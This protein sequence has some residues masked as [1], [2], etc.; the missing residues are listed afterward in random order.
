MKLIIGLGNPGKK[1]EN[2]RHNV[3]FM[4]VDNVVKNFNGS[5]TLNTKLRCEQF[6][7][8]IKGEKVLF[9]KPITYMNL[10]GESIRLVVDYYKANIE[11]I[12]VIYDDLDLP[13]GKI[14]LRENGSSGGHKGM[15]S[16]IDHLKTNNIKRMRIG[17][18]YIFKKD[19]ID[20]VLGK[21]SKD[22]MDL[23]NDVL[24]KS[25]DI[26]NDFIEKSFD[27][28]MNIYNKK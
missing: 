10:S 21:F 4:F 12:L 16:I 8:T 13:C 9:V 25:N 7:M 11:D 5:Y 3:G 22:E 15:Q 2:T 18:D 19:V 17:I 6:L 1:Y 24:F 26:I 27:A 28:L 14:R 20:Y 23:I